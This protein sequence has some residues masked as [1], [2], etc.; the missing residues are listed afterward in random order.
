MG[1]QLDAFQASKD[2]ADRFAT[3]VRSPRAG[4][5]V[6]V[7]ANW[8]V[9]SVL[10]AMLATHYYLVDK[11]L[12]GLLGRHLSFATLHA[13]ASSA[14]GEIFVWVVK[15]DTAAV[16]AAKDATGH[17]SNVAWKNET[18]SYLVKAAETDHGEPTWRFSTFDEMIEAA[19]GDRILTSVDQPEVEAIRA[20]KASTRRRRPPSSE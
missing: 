18:K 5:D 7:N 8:L 10:V 19:F 13:V 12:S 9:K 2:L 16:T 17:W 20:K 6:W 15:D 11:K 3:V 4:E 14:K 1:F